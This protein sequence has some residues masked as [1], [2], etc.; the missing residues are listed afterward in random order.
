MGPKAT[1][2]IG[3][4]TLALSSKLNLKQLRSAIFAHPTLSESIS[5]ALR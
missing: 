4:L 2:I 5:E 3:I 1:E